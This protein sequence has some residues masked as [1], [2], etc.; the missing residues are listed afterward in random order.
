MLIVLACLISIGKEFHS[1]G[2]NEEKALSPID[3]KRVKGTVRRPVSDEGHVLEY[4]ELKAQTN[5]EVP[6][7]VKPCK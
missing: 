2:A 7:H 6:T 5:I 4:K 1:F 3:L